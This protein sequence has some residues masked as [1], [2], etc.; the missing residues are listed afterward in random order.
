MTV[1][2]NDPLVDEVRA[3][4]QKHAA[5][6]SYDLNEIFRDIQAQQQSS[7]RKFVRYPARPATVIAALESETE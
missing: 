5:Q 2:P 1:Q 7:G 6:F 3:A 4:R